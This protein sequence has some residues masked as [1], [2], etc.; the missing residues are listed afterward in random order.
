MFSSLAPYFSFLWC[1]SYLLFFRTTHLF[2]LPTPVPYANAV[3]L[4]LTLKSVG[5]AFEVQDSHTR[6]KKLQEL[7]K[8]TRSS[9]DGESKAQLEKLRLE[10]EYLSIDASFLD[11][12]FY[13]YCHFGI[14]TGPYFRFRT[15]YDW[16]HNSGYVNEIDSLYFLV[17]RGMPLPLMIALFLFLSKY[18]S[19]QVGSS[20]PF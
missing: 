18:I 4:V 3:Q 19:F 12:L 10:N 5:L 7:E 16:L 1:F 20:F 17:R 15:Y 13:S 9:G 8:S 11:I 2:G 14:L 6:R